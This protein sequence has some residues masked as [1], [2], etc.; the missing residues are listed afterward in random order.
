MRPLVDF[1]NC[2]SHGQ[3]MSVGR[4][5]LRKIFVEFKHCF[6]YFG[7]MKLSLGINIG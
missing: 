2:K 5:V 3:T 6:L 1:P 4:F 7:R